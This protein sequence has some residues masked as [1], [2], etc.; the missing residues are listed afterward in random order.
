MKWKTAL[1]AEE[2]ALLITGLS[3]Y[4]SSLAQ[5]KDDLASNEVTNPYDEY[6]V[7]YLNQKA[8]FDEAVSLKE[9]LWDEIRHAWI[10]R[11]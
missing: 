7:D 3:K 2:A 9:A 1:T 6:Y 11:N 5:V 8:N 10:Y 4:Y